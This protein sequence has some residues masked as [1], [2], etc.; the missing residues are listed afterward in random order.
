MQANYHKKS[1]AS[2]RGDAVPYV[3][4]GVYAV[5]ASLDPAYAA[6]NSVKYQNLEGASRN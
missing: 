5:L 4:D 3:K 2:H 1:D 6:G